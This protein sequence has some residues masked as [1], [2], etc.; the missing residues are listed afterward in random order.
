LLSPSVNPKND[1]SLGPST[2]GPTGT[3]ASGAAFGLS[4]AT[5]IGIGVGV[6]YYILL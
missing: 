3:D 2:A 4:S 1:A 5:E 6:L